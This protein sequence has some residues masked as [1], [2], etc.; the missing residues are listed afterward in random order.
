MPSTGAIR[1]VIPRMCAAATE[2]G[3]LRHI[4]F[5]FLKVVIPQAAEKTQDGQ[6]PT[7]GGQDVLCRTR[8]IR[9]LEVRH[10]LR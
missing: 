4:N 3:L 5:A 7:A 1:N 2:S 9:G 8:G 10:T 6:Q